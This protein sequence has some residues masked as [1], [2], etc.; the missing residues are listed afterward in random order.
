METDSLVYQLFSESKDYSY[1]GITDDPN[2]IKEQFPNRNL[3]DFTIIRPLEAFKNN[4]TPSGSE[5]EVINKW[6]NKLNVIIT[7]EVTQKEYEFVIYKIQCI[8][9]NI[10]DVYIGQ[11]VHFEQRVIAHCEDLQVKDTKV[12]SFINAHG[13]IHN[14]TFTI[15]GKYNIEPNRLEWYWW[16]KYGA[17]LNS[18]TPGLKFVT[19][20][21]KKMNFTED[22]MVHV[23]EI[24]EYC[25]QI[26]SE[27]KFPFKLCDPK[28]FYLDCEAP[29]IKEPEKFINYSTVFPL[30]NKNLVSRRDSTL[31]YRSDTDLQIYEI[32][33]EN[34]KKFLGLMIKLKCDVNKNI[35]SQKRP[36]GPRVGEGDLRSP[37][38]L[39]ALANF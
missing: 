16:K 24:L 37:R 6:V 39:P 36:F 2:T 7:K 4:S 1:I 3:E 35:E 10:T 26:G 38:A 5:L 19:N 23:Y 29:I 9:P 33:C 28:V 11:T 31:M 34:G 13:G 12:Y 20:D 8:D 18:V 32:I 25:S 30:W 15:L 27:I 17:T 14:W 21:M 22:Q